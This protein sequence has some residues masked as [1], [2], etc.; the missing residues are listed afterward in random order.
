MAT[1]TSRPMVSET[2]IANQALSWLG[3]TQIESLEEPTRAAEFARNNYQFLRDSVIED[4]NWSFAR[5][6]KVSG[7]VAEQPDWDTSL[8]E[9]NLP[10]DWISV[11]DVRTM[12]NVSVPEW[13]REGRAV[14]APESRVILIG[15]ERVVDTGRF[16]PLF[17]QALAARLAYAMAVPIAGSSSRQ[18]DM[19]A[20]YDNFI[21]A[22]DGADR[23]Q[24]SGPGA[25]DTRMVDIRYAGGGIAPFQHGR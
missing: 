21:A 12:H 13:F 15:L 16:T 23:Q 25:G 5:V 3:A 19:E 10:L 14:Y 8:F 6:R 22:A 9:H 7:P 17:V 4:G 20:M 11:R 2:S 1:Q 18:K 24:N